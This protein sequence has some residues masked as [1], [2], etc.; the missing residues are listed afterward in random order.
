MAARKVCVV[1]SSNI[2]VTT[3]IGA[4]IVDLVRDLGPDIV[5]LTRGSGEVD[6][7]IATIAPL[8]ELRCFMF[9]AEGGASNFLRDIELVR[10]CDEVIAIC[11]RRDLEKKAES[12]TLHVVAKA[13][14]QEKRVRLYTVLDD[15]SLV[16]VAENDGGEETR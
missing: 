8:L 6:H 16:G 15:G 1:G 14:D 13:L 7:F 5:L 9:P 12:G 4:A 2:E 3:S 10:S 11:S